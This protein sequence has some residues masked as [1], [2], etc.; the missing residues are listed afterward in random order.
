VAAVVVV[1]AA[2]AVVAAVVVVATVA[3]A[4]VAAATVVA[5]A[6]AVVVVT[7][8]VVVAAVAVAEA[9][10]VAAAVVAVATTAAAT[11]VAATAV[12]KSHS[13]QLTPSWKY[14]EGFSLTWVCQ[15]LSIISSSNGS[16]NMA[17]KTKSQKDHWTPR[18]NV[19]LLTCMDLRFLDDVV[20]F[21][22]RHN[23][24]NRYDHVVFAGASLGVLKG[25]SPLSILDSP[26][27]RADADHPSSWKAVFFDHIAV[28]IN[29]LHRDI[30]DIAILEHEDCGAYHLFLP[31]TKDDCD[32][33]MKEHRHYADTLVKA[34]EDLREV[35]VENAKLDL[36]YYLEKLN[37]FNELKKLNKKET[38]EREEIID[39]VA[40]ARFRK[41]KWTKLKVTAFIMDLNGHVD[42][43]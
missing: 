37:E 31:D 7:A 25:N 11:T 8:A 38:K 9:A 41:E 6:A 18:K 19:F 32:R 17:K 20:R 33:E 23:L 14:H 4:V 16:L 36:E 5:A 27:H 2:T 1:A 21:M 28:A 26:V 13:I 34:L 24:Q 10:T 30:S 3:A 42:P 39:E 40:G 12:T 22:E 29:K 15:S 43:L 35:Q